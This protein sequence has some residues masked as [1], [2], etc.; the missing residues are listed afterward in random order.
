MNGKRASPTPATSHPQSSLSRRSSRSRSIHLDPLTLDPLT[1]EPLTVDPLTLEPLEPLTL[2][3]L[4]VDPL[5]LEPLEPLT[6]DPLTVDPLALDDW[7]EGQIVPEVE[8]RGSGVVIV[9]PHSPHP[10]RGSELCSIESTPPDLCI[11]SAKAVAPEATLS[12]TASAPAASKEMDFT[13]ELLIVLRLTGNLSSR[14]SRGQ[15]ASTHSMRI[16][17]T[18]VTSLPA[19]DGAS[20]HAQ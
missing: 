17:R 16:I 1:L 13:R 9:V 18:G 7:E 5:T 12:D 6:V 11:V 19:A 20:F 4:T 15:T 8:S 10:T 3:P 2:E 14:T